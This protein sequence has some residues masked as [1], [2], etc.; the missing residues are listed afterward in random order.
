V[1][2]GGDLEVVPDNTFLNVLAGTKAVP[3]KEGMSLEVQPLEEMLSFSEGAYVGEMHQ[4]LEAREVQQRFF[5]EGLNMFK[6]TTLGVT[7]VL[8]KIAE[9]MDLDLVKRK[10][11]DWWEAM[12]TKV[13]LWV[14]QKFPFRR[15]VWVKV[16]GIPIHVWDEHLF[17]KIGNLFGDFVDF[18]EE[19]IARKRL[20]FSRIKVST[21]KMVLINDVVELVVV[22]RVS[23]Y[24][25]WRREVFIGGEG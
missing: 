11:E 4:D 1:V 19:T 3:R 13:T 24:G 5:M 18:D 17:K 7:R 23:A 8:L 16:W 20:D 21:E 9:N 6:V 12:F 10:H 2:K 22:G 25:W 15:H 14:P